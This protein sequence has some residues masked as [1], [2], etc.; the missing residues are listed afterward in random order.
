MVNIKSEKKDINSS[1]GEIFSF[2]SDFNNFQNLM[3]E[4][5]VNWQSDE[6]SCTFTIK[7]MAD[8]G[9]KIEDKIFP[10]KIK[11]IS[12]GKN[13]FTFELLCFIEMISEKN[14]NVC[15]HFNANLNPMLAMM[16]KKPLQNLVNI[17]VEKLQEKF[18]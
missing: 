15:L 7:G 5:I 1:A 14:S 11:I 8:I 10:E 13:P 16:A 4:Q 3:P 9:M 17:M 2:L 12:H 6:N 18:I